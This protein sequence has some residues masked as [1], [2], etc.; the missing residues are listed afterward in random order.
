V[1]EIRLH[2]HIEQL[3]NYAVPMMFLL[4]GSSKQNI[5]FER[6]TGLMGMEKMARLGR[7]IG[8]RSSWHAWGINHIYSILAA[9]V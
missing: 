1:T 4:K 8:G 7:R 9:M 3:P 2:N 6:E 5:C